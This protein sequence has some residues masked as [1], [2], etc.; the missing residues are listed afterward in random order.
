MEGF[1]TKM[2]KLIMLLVPISCMAG[3]YYDDHDGAAKK[4]FMR[5]QHETTQRH[6]EAKKAT[7][8]MVSLV[9]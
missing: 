9:I 2:K 3:Y 5:Y 8:R 6:F 7:E 4:N 1:T